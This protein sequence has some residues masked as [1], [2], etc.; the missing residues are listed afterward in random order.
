MS[1]LVLSLLILLASFASARISPRLDAPLCTTSFMLRDMRVQLDA[2]GDDSI[3]IRASPDEIQQI[4]P[5]QALLPFPPGLVP[6][7]SQSL[8]C[9][10]TADDELTNGNLKVT[11]TS[12]SL[13]A[14]RVSDGAVLLDVTDAGFTPVQFDSVYRSNYSLFAASISYTHLHGQ[15]Y[16]LGE[17]KTNRTAYDDYSHLFEN[18][19]VYDFSAGGD[20]SIPF[21]ISSSGFGVL[22]NQ[23][24]YGSIHITQ[25]AATW[26]S[27]ATHQLDLWITVA[28]ADS[29]D[30][31]PF[32]ALSRNYAE[33]TG[34]PNVLPHYASGFWQS[35]DRY[36]S[37]AGQRVRG[38]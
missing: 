35:K 32:P 18:S 13:Q 20:I 9:S 38:D 30:I 5:I 19:Q 11:L 33:V 1:V 27:N 8:P 14:V 2:W 22:Y 23:A 12:D 34:Y 31:T 21:Y 17:H 4:P 15:V 37:V 36:A 29:S 7:P 3:R 26:T 25:D 10:V 6:P 16:G 24:G 28:P